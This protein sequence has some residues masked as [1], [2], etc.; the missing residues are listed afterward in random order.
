[1]RPVGRWFCSSIKFLEGVLAGPAPAQGEPDARGTA[2]G[3][4]GKR[5]IESLSSLCA[6]LAFVKLKNSLRNRNADDRGRWQH[7]CQLWGRGRRC[8]PH[9]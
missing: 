2:W 6:Q 9:I 1:M 4:L 8:S 7:Q 5:H 3:F